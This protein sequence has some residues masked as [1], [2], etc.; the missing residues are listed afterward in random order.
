MLKIS[1]ILVSSNNIYHNVGKWK[2]QPGRVLWC[3]GLGF[4]FHSYR[5][6]EDQEELIFDIK[7][8]GAIITN[9]KK[10]HS[11]K[12]WK[13]NMK[14]TE[15]SPSNQTLVVVSTSDARLFIKT[16][17]HLRLFSHGPNML[18]HWWITFCF[19]MFCG[20]GL[21]CFCRPTQSRA[22]FPDL[23]EMLR[24]CAQAQI[25]MKIQYAHA[26][27]HPFPSCT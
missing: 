25:C 27:T 17:T 8:R 26:Q 12:K 14:M 5:W 21:L 22:M 13:L 15:S 18:N 20:V 6:S 2:C 11:N 1:R 19:S 24:L 9:C 23:H 4:H 16:A 10:P 7:E 3:W